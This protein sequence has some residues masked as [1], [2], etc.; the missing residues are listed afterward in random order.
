[1]TNTTQADLEREDARNKTNG[2]FGSHTHT[3]PEA[4]LVEEATTA[5]VAQFDNER[6]TIAQERYLLE[7]KEF[8]L[9]CKII[10]TY[11]HAENL[12]GIAHT[13]YLEDVSDDGE[14]FWSPAAIEDINGKVLWELDNSDSAFRDRLETYAP[15]LGHLG[16]R[17]LELNDYLDSHGIILNPPTD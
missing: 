11:I 14:P 10:E 7:K 12:D 1:M 3:A 5:T 4:A 8:D 9:T 17:H 16:T 2:E 13:L 6:Y 15:L